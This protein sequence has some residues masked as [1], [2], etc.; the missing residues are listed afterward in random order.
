MPHAQGHIVV[1][2]RP[3]NGNDGNPGLDGCILRVSEWAKNVH[4]TNDESK[5]GGTRYID[6]CVV[7]TGANSFQCYKCIL[8]HDSSDSITYTNTK[9]W[10]KFNKL[11]PIYTPLIMAQNALLRFTQTNQLLVMKSDNSTVA[12]GMGGGAFPLWVGAV[13]PEKAPFR[14]SIDGKL[15]ATDA[16][17]TGTINADKGRIGNFKI[18]GSHIGVY[19]D[20][21]FAGSGGLAIFNDF[22]KF[23]TTNIW[24][25]IGTDVLP[26]SSGLTALGRFENHKENPYGTNIGVLI[27]VRN[28]F[29]NVALKVVGD[30][31]A[32]GEVVADMV[33]SVKYRVVTDRDQFGKVTKYL[34]GVDMDFSQDLDKYRLQVRNGI[35]VGVR[36]E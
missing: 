30:I 34:D 16:D 3:R 21:E 12:A 5:R 35:I 17:I 2:R 23:S 33:S 29:H 4:Y 6:I 31:Y 24:A 32:Q 19:V 9:Y 26:A 27:D 11:Q 18:E 28:A 15:T 8:E 13:T 20:D 1:K 10:Q 36:H 14:V 25:G 7:T 22:I